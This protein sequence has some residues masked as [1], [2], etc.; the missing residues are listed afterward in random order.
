MGDPIVLSRLGP[1]KMPSRLSI[2]RII[3]TFQKGQLGLPLLFG[4]ILIVASG[5]GNAT[6]IYKWR[7]ANG[8]IHY[9]QR[10]P[11]GA[12][13]QKFLLVDEGKPEEEAKTELPDLTKKAGVTAE[14]AATADKAPKADRQREAIAKRNRQAECDSSR[15]N[16]RKL[17][18]WSHRA[19]V[20]DEHGNR[21]R[22]DSAD[23]AQ[24]IAR[25]EAREK[26]YCD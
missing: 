18:R 6:E 1:G 21:H 2:A 14:Q 7:D 5:N 10:P 25:A 22:L 24:L 3:A 20:R 15:E 19:V 16:L 11:E 13:T 4:V 26:E 12:S 17:Q 23:R 8:Q 9:G